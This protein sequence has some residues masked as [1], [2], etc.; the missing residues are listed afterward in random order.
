MAVKKNLYCVEISDILEPEQERFVIEK[1]KAYV[2]KKEEDWEEYFETTDTLDI[3][4]LAEGEAKQL[5][6]SLE[7]KDLSV[8]VYQIGE[9]AE[10][11][12]S[13]KSRCP[14]CGHVMEF[15]DWRCPECFYEF[16]DYEFE[17]S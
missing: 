17:D 13:R 11:M 16:P 15:P 2:K 1:V 14:R 8:R 3:K 12:E 6:S 5:A 4:R 9:K 10:E 7:G